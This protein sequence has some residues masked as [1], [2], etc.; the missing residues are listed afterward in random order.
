MILDLFE[1][2][3]FLLQHLLVILWLLAGRQRILSLAWCFFG[4]SWLRGISLYHYAPPLL[5]SMLALCHILSLCLFWHF[6][7][8]LLGGERATITS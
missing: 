2:S 8:D 7:L 1:L 6:W 4:A 3:D 5:L